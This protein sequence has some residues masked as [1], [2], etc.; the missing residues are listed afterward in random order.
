M[1][2]PPWAGRRRRRSGACRT[3]RGGPA[4]LY[5][6]LQHRQLHVE[7]RERGERERG[8]RRGGTRDAYIVK[9]KT[10]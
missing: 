5:A 2:A 6:L 10:V 1:R 8:R 4:W 7:E 3:T 9:K